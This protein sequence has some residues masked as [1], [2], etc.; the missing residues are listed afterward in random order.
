V[1]EALTRGVA[2]A[3]TVLSMASCAGTP[4]DAVRAAWEA[5]EQEKVETYIQAF[6]ERSGDLLRGM[7][8]TSER[9][10]GALTYLDPLADLLPTGEIIADRVE[11]ELGLVKVAAAN[12]E[13]EIQCVRERGA[14]VIDG[15]ELE[16]LWAP[17]REAT[18]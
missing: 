6:T 4:G 7:I 5:R 17:L 15:L 10:R 12:G 16:A 3:L 14:W 11:G 8:A 13:Y 18:R 2:L 1:I 9:T